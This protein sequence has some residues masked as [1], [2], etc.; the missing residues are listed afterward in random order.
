MTPSPS[1][2]RTYKAPAALIGAAL[3]LTVMAPTQAVARQDP[4]AASWTLK[5]NPEANRDG[6]DAFEGIEDD[7]AD[8]HSGVKHIYTQ[9]NNFRFDMHNRDRD[10]SDRQRNE[11][12]GMRQ[13]A[14][15]SYLVMRNGE[16]WRFTWRLFIPNSLKSTTTFTHIM[17]MKAPG[18]GGPI[19]VQ[20]LRRVNGEQTIELQAALTGTIVGRTDLEPLHDK[21]IDIDFEMKIGN[22]PDGRIRWIVRD[23]SRTVIDASKSGLDTW[24]EDRVR[25]KWGIYRSIN[26]TSGSLRDSYM[27]TTNM[28]GYQWQ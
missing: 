1:S 10:G 17:Q 18:S 27:L 11:V 15:G 21:W 16:T 22:A 8:S 2:P 5:W 20:S 26:D 19:V 4:R 9:G 13:P 23:G 25:P 7:R 28:R 6:L 24:L 12:K 14:G 3:A